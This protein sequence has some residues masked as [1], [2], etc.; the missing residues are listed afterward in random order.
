MGS[1]NDHHALVLTA[2]ITVTDG[3]IDGTVHAAGQ[4][5]QMFSGWSELFG[6]LTRLVGEADR[7][8]EGLDPPERE[9]S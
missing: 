2:E 1:M 4:P 7:Q 5:G 3:H 9:A 8:P 6:V